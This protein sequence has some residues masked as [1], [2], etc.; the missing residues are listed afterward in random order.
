VKRF[1]VHTDVLTRKS[2]FLAAARKSEW[3]AGDSSK[4][5][6]LSDEDPDVFQDY[7]NCVYSGP[8]ILGGSRKAIEREVLD[9]IGGIRDIVVEYLRKEITDEQLTAQFESFGEIKEFTISDDSYHS[10]A[11]ISFATAEAGREAIE[12]CDGLFMNGRVLRVTADRDC[13]KGST[14]YTLREIELAD[15]H[16][17]AL[18]N[19][20]LLADKLRDISTAN[21]VLDK[22]KH[23]LVITDVHP[24]KEAISIAY[25]STTEGNPL[26][27][28]LRDMWFY[29][30][31]FACRKR[32][33]E[34]GFP[35]DFLYDMVEQ[36]VGV[37]TIDE[38][39]NFAHFTDTMSSDCIL[40][41]PE[42]NI[43]ERCRYHQ[44]D[45]EHPVCSMRG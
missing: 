6:D 28:L 8:D 38:S 40:D 25:Q 9:S 18:I 4:P 35:K 41:G 21:N 34:G 16:Y 44:H 31:S 15:I 14:R 27:R 37:K 7:L 32:L 3:L 43:P 29:G 36:Y 13:A 45:D 26:R 17:K 22:I 12:V 10:T 24:G 42:R 33:Q 19:V 11:S 2:K 1:T 39:Y 20:Y 23:F 30:T 5:V